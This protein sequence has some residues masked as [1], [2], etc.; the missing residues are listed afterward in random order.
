MTPD[1][2]GTVARFG[3]YALALPAVALLWFIHRYA[4]N[5]IF[6]DQWH[7]IHI[8][9][10]SHSGTLTLGDL[11]AQHGENRVFVPD[12]LVL[13]LARTTHFNV[14]YEDYGSGILLIA[15]AA[16]LIL[17][18]RRRSPSTPWIY[19]FPVVI[20]LLSLNQGTMTM[21]GFAVS[22]YL[23]IFALAAAL[24]L[25][26]RVALGWL[27]LAGAIA[28][29]IAGAFS[30][31]EGLLIWP[32]GLLL[33]YHRRRG[34]A[35][36][37]AWITAAVVTT[38]VYLYRFDF[39]T[40]GTGTKSFVLT[41][42]VLA[43][44][45]F[46]FAIGDVF[47][48]QVPNTP[49]AGDYLFCLL[50]VLIFVVAAWVLVV[51]LP[52]RDRST[53]S[54]IGVAAVLF[55]VLYT[56]ALTEGRGSLGLSV[57][58]RYAIFELLILAGCYLAML[59]GSLFEERH[60][61][62]ANI[63]RRISVASLI[64]RMEGTERG[65]TDGPWWVRID[66]LGLRAAL[67]VALCLQVVI[68]PF[69]AFSAAETWHDQ[70][71]AAA[72]IAVNIGR[73]PNS[74]VR[75]GLGSSW[76]P[77]SYIRSMAQAARSEHLSLFDTASAAYYSSRGLTV[78]KTPPITRVVIPPEGSTVTGTS[79]L[80]AKA[81]DPYGVKQVTFILTGGSVHNLVIGR[82]HKT[83]Y[84]WATSWNTSLVANGIYSIRSVA[85]D[86]I[87]TSSHSAEVQVTVRN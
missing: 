31:L 78:D 23:E 46:F 73:A 47:G 37:L 67:I 17:A 24:F 85:Y 64:R 50:G 57:L 69:E 10:L 52:R 13:V 77:V 22:W 42:P 38:G 75:T 60:G 76:Q 81:S 36:V 3:I 49:S 84:G 59:D 16:L 32:V 33:L 9:A 65:S 86:T 45:F 14:V 39:T 43:V 29:A 68:A 1:P 82:A 48:V 56:V 44:R 87:G 2:P 74:L 12:L 34:R 54:P 4:V 20:V 27:G 53:A 7:D 80:I 21:W 61:L 40:A 55:G 6:A 41:H 58:P 79:G 25:L 35:M 19:Y 11:W 70:E 83:I 5:M 66:H 72:D 71:L 26:D 62:V 18:H 8:I 15:T 28:V 63:G 51:G 30:S